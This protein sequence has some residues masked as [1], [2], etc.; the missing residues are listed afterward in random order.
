MSPA[1]T[2]VIHRAHDEDTEKRSAEPDIQRSA[3]GCPLA[4]PDRLT[5]HTH[6]DPLSAAC[7]PRP[8]WAVR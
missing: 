7:W 5:A 8:G 1:T 2:Y 3:A 4:T 6:G